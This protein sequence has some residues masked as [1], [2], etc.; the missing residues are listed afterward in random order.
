V[1]SEPVITGHSGAPPLV[2]HHGQTGG[3]QQGNQGQPQQFGNQGG[4]PQ[5]RRGPPPPAAAA[6][7]G[8]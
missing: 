5:Q 1:K 2:L 4:T 3:L 8:R 7:W 6:Q